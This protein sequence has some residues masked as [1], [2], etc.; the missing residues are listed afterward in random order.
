MFDGINDA[1]DDFPVIDAWNTMWAWKEGLDT[2]ELFGRMV[3]KLAHD[4]LPEHN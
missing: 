2:F 1:A 4:V 3:E